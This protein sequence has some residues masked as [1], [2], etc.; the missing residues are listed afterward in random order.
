MIPAEEAIHDEKFMF[1]IQKNSGC[2]KDENTIGKYIKQENV[3]VSYKKATNFQI[4]K[5]AEI[6][7]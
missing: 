3:Q 6:Q 5:Q 2:E 7:C 4:I 1:T